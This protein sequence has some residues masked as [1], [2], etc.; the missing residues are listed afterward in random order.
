MAYIFMDES[1]DL[2]FSKDKKNS[3]YFIVTFLFI[4]DKKPLDKIIK[5]VF[6][7]LSKKSIKISWWVLHCTKEKSTTRVRLLSLCKKADMYIMTIYLNKSKVYTHLQNEKHILYNYVVNILLDRITTKKIIP[8]KGTI[9]FIASRRETSKLLNQNFLWY[10]K[11]NI[12]SKPFDIKFN[13]KTPLQEKWLQVVD[14]C[15]RAIYQKYE[16]QEEDY[17]TLIKSLIIEEKWLFS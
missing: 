17:Y 15:C 11:K 12:Q 3:K 1:W 16:K 10:L 6:S 7:W 8:T 9:E 5:K 2:G 13:I 14:F 4:N